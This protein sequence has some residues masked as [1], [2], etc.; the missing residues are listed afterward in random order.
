M[1]ALWSIVVAAGTGD[2][3]GGPKQYETLGDRRVLDWSIAALQ[4]YSDGIV[5]V[6][7]EAF[8]DQPEPAVSTVAPGGATRA[9]SVRRGLDRVPIEADLIAVH[10]AA[11]P[12]A[13]AA[14]VG[15]LVEALEDGADGVVPALPVVD[16][17]KRL[18]GPWSSGRADVR[19][20]VDRAALVAVQTPQVFRASALRAAHA[21]G[22]EGT[23][24]AS[25]VEA[26]GGKVLAVEGEPGNIKITSRHD[27]DRLRRELAP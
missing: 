9:E 4:P 8:R 3:F 19:E 12:M 18:A 15:R 5:L 10:D 11:R 20:T 21:A 1:S 22:A 24:D 2:R 16:T 7:H 17:I 13:S 26:A 23:D 14:L 27:L 6:V 25:L